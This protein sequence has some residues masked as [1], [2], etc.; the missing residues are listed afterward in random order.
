MNSPWYPYYLREFLSI[1]SRAKDRWKIPAIAHPGGSWHVWLGY[2][3]FITVGIFT[4]AMLK[5]A[6]QIALRGFDKY[7]NAKYFIPLKETILY[8]P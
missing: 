3:N 4:L 2:V 1:A 6:V 7:S 5:S 8:I